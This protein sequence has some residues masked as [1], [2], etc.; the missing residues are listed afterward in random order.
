MALTAM[1]PNSLPHGAMWDET[2]VPALRKRVFTSTSTA[3][4]LSLTY[5]KGLENESIA[6]SKRMS[7]ASMA[8]NEDFSHSGFS[9]NASYVSR[10]KAV[11]PTYQPQKPSAIPRPSL[12]QSRPAE[13][14]TSTNVR[15]SRSGSFQRSRTFSQP[16]LFDRSTANGFMPAQDSSARS[17]SPMSGI[18]STRIPVSRVR[19]GSVSSGKQPSL[20]GSAIMIRSDSRNGSSKANGQPYQ[21]HVDIAPDLWPVNERQQPSSVTSRINLRSQPSHISELVDE[22]PPF[23]ANSMSSRRGYHDDYPRMSAESEERPFEHWYRGDVSRNGGVG[24]L[25]VGRRQEMLDIA[26]YGHSLREASSR[27]T[28]NRSR[29]NSRGRDMTSQSGRRPRAESLGARESIYIDDDSRI[30]QAHMV[31]DE[32]PPTDFDSDGED[33]DG[34]DYYTDAAAYEPAS[35]EEKELRTE[36]AASMERS[37]TPSTLVEA[38]KATNPNYKSRIP[39]PTP[40]QISESS[41]AETPAQSPSLSPEPLEPKAKAQ[42]QKLAVNTNQA[43]TNKRRAKSP[44]ATPS[45]TKKSRTKSPAKPPPRKKQE[46]RGSV[47]QYPTLEG[48]DMANAIPTWTQPSMPPSGNWDDVSPVDFD[49]ETLMECSYVYYNRRYYL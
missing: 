12:Q 36:P 2:I 45:S 23:N 34:L 24:E 4:Q 1:S 22:Q 16:L 3:I 42:P 40:R 44:A 39:T 9:S 38:S 46:V 43:A 30:H 5:T 41:R 7:A 29:S 33:Y 8:S 37:D 13:I 14:S 27:T 32:N 19:T 11:S 17:A 21:S 26:N 35:L 25:R 15:S 18:K 47:A 49:N 48:D 20:N 31:F 10:D 28:L 6:L